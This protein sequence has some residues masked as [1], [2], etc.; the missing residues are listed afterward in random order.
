MLNSRKLSDAKILQDNFMDKSLVLKKVNVGD[1]EIWYNAETQA[2]KSAQIWV[3]P[4]RL[5]LELS[6]EQTQAFLRVCKHYFEDLESTE[7]DECPPYHLWADTNFDYMGPA[8]DDKQLFW[9]SQGPLSMYTQTERVRNVY[10]DLKVVL[11]EL[12]GIERF[13]SANC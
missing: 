2:F 1:V 3:A 13:T 12:G 8:K 4:D 9:F 11:E 10:R 6:L 5:R 7:N